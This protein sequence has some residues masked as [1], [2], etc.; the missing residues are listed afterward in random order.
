MKYNSDILRRFS[1]NQLYDLLD[2]YPEEEAI[3]K[4]LNRRFKMIKSNTNLTPLQEYLKQ[5]PT[6]CLKELKKNIITQ[7]DKFALQDIENEIICR[8]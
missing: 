6:K 3:E 1:I 4:E 5:L 7:K 8:S 2:N